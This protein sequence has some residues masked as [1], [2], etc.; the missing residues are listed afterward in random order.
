M[1]WFGGVDEKP[2]MAF[3]DGAWYKSGRASLEGRAVHPVAWDAENISATEP[4]E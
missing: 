3:Y 2:G 4:T 1:V